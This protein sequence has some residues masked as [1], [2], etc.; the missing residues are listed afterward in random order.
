M[1]NMH[2]I[3]YVNDGRII[4]ITSDSGTYNKVTYDCYFIDN[5]KATDSET[6]ILSNNL[7]LIS[8]KDTASIYNNVEIT[9]E[10]GSLFADRVDY[11]FKTKYYRVS[12][13]ENNSNSEKVKIKVIQ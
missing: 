8:S 13:F 6:I 9:G 11:N 2:V 4:N 3:L 5:V 1:K 12:M 10:R 7:D